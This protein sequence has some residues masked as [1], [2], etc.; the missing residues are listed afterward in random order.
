MSG[1]L[2]CCFAVFDIHD[3]RRSGRWD[4]FPFDDDDGED[5]RH[6]PIFFQGPLS[7]FRYKLQRIHVVLWCRPYYLRGCPYS[8]FSP[9]T[10]AGM[11]H[12][13]PRSEESRFRVQPSMFA[14]ENESIRVIFRRT[15]LL[16]M[17]LL[18]HDCCLGPSPIA[19][20]DIVL[21]IFLT[22]TQNG[23]YLPHRQHWGSWCRWQEDSGPFDKCFSILPSFEGHILL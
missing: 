18:L 15:L 19:P 2:R 3:I 17:T 12:I 5:P 4:A 14:L 20:L 10:S 23:L 6:F 9:V 21:P 11:S 16:D 8:Q 7:P 22:S 13:V 1:R